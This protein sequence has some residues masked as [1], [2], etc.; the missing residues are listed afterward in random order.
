[1]SKKAV[2]ELFDS[3]YK[4]TDLRQMFRETAPK[5]NFDDK[6]KDEVFEILDEVEKSLNE[7][8]GEVKK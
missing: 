1:M 8:R 3:L 4:L 7:I 6:Q 2:E 5:H